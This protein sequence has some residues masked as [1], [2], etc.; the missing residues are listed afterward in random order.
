M[1]KAVLFDLDGTIRHNDPRRF[2]VFAA[3]AAQLGLRVREDDLLRAIRWEHYYWAISREYLDDHARFNGQED[4]FWLAYSHRQLVALGA[5]TAQAVE[6][7]PKMQE[8]MDENYEP[9]SVI[10][11]D[12]PGVL[13]TLND[14]GRK[15]GVV[16]NRREP[17]Q[18]EVAELG[19][20]AYFAFSLASGEINVWKP[21]AE[22]FLHA[23]KRMDVRPE[24]AAYVGDNY[25]ADV[26]GA[27][28]AGVMPVLYDPREVF[29][30]PECAVIRSFVAL[31]RVL[32]VDGVKQ[33]TNTPTSPRGTTIATR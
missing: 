6:L 10:P 23:C 16:S 3:Q 13:E 24:E 4:G 15:L 2:D 27:R 7:A 18:D 22:I 28:R 11:D 8:Y 25:F 1:I 12:L 26:V 32:G 29:D 33:G 9:R 31:P 19:L 21:D 5:S 30:D 14:A 17:I 20:A